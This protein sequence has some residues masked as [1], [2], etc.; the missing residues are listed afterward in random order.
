[1][2]DCRPYAPLASHREN[3]GAGNA[4]RV[5]VRNGKPAVIA[6][7]GATGLR[8]PGHPGWRDL[9]QSFVGASDGWQ[10]LVPHGRLTRYVDW[11][12]NGDVALAEPQPQPGATMPAPAGV[13][14]PDAAA[15]PGAA[16]DASPD[17]AMGV[18][19]H[20]VRSF[21]V[22]PLSAVW[23][24]AQGGADGGEDCL[25][26]PR[27]LVAAAGGHDSGGNCQTVADSSAQDSHLGVDHVDMPT[28][29]V[30]FGAPIRLT[31]CRPRPARWE[32]RAFAAC[33]RPV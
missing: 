25:A 17:R 26:G 33:V 13:Q 22:A 6:S 32:G 3:Q 19:T 14:D 12:R 27:D 7:P 15:H 30:V 21:P 16:V 1:L 10:D 11:S 31:L 9:S 4:A 5:G 8:L 29:A 2:D 23:R 20:P 18:C 24:W 28:P